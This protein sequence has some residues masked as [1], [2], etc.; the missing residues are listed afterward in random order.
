[1]SEVVNNFLGAYG[2]VSN[3]DT[4]ISLIKSMANI[5]EIDYKYMNSYAE[6]VNGAI[7]YFDDRLIELFDNDFKEKDSNYMWVD[8]GY[9]KGRY[10]IYASFYKSPLGWEGAF[11]GTEEKLRSKLGKYYHKPSCITLKSEDDSN[12]SEAYNG[13]TEE[14]FN[15][16]DRSRF[17]A[18]I[19]KRL[20]IKEY[21]AKSKPGAN[22]ISKYLDAVCSK[23][24]FNIKK[25][26]D[27]GYI[28]NSDKSGIIINTGLLDKYM[29]D[30]FVYFKIEGEKFIEPWIIDSKRDMVQ[31]GFD[32]EQVKNM[33]KPVRFY[34]S[35]E[36][37]IFHGDINDFDIEDGNRLNH[38]INERRKRFPAEYANL[39][40]DVI[41]SKLKTAIERAVKISERDYKYIVPMYNSSEDKLQFLIPLHIEKSIEE[42]PELVLVVFKVDGFYT[43]GTILNTGEAYDNARVI[44]KP[45]N[46]WLQPE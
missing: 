24:Q 31:K 10:S 42:A 11:I 17:C 28:I 46:T 5:E 2:N 7:R 45:G 26:V 1:M 30:I 4:C 20:I 36:E 8:T 34:N 41:C 19:Y 6:K 21:W 16:L 13:L 44:A 23:I 3:I 18:E 25:N 37:L 39:S 32:K 15:S 22:R 29:N 40:P 35:T 14:E 38:I 43:V 33:P 9:K 12:I 27:N